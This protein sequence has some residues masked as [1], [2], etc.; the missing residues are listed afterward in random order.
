MGGIFIKNKGVRVSEFSLRIKDSQGGFSLIEVS[1]A[2]LVFSLLAVPYF[3]LQDIKT[4]KEVRTVTEQNIGEI[5]KAALRRYVLDNGRYPYPAHKNLGPGDAGYGEAFPIVITGDEK[6]VSFCNEDVDDEGIGAVCISAGAGVTPIP[7]VVTGALPFAT[8]GLP[9][10]YAYD[11]YAAKLTYSVSLLLVMENYLD[12]G[13][14]FDVDVDFN[15]MGGEVSVVDRDGNLEG[16]AHYAIVSHGADQKGA[17]S[18]DGQLI[19]PCNTDGIGTQDSQN[20]DGNG[21][22]TNNFGAPDNTGAQDVRLEYTGVQNSADY[23]DD[24]VGYETT[25]IRGYW[26]REAETSDVFSRAQNVLIGTLE[27]GG[28]LQPETK[29]EVVG[30]ISADQLRT[31]RLC[32]PEGC[33]CFETGVQTRPDGHDNGYCAQGIS[34]ASPKGV[35]DPKI[36]A[37]IPVDGAAGAGIKCAADMPLTGISEADEECN[38]GG[39]LASVNIV[40]GC[41]IDGSPT[42][43]TGLTVVDGAVSFTCTIP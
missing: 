8:L 38:S 33:G 14:A 6:N 42:Y 32:P 29:M 28:Q 2:L 12:I 23:Y 31:N 10:R 40:G 11:G 43:P 9:E 1:L 18:R 4:A 7:I 35:F 26:S 30:N 3:K 39:I 20:C 24:Y 41:V 13:L 16:N 27:V 21:T 19:S 37:G 5:T 22:F 36:I 17:F 25:S 34:G 15:E